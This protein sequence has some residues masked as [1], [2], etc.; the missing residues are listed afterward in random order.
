MAKKI[1]TLSM[2]ATKEITVSL[3]PVTGSL[4]LF[5]AFVNGVKVIQEDGT[6]KRTWPGK[7]PDAQVRIKIRVVG[8]E[9]ASFKFGVDIP[10]TAEEQ[11]LTL[12]LR[13]GYYEAEFIL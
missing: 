11:S 1:V 2:Q 12:K 7:I 10:G 8:I 13:D 3:E 9:N 4:T 5:Y 6:K